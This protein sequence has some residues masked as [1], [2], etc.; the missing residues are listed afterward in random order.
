VI[1]VLV[2]DITKNNILATV[3][4][5]K[6][7]SVKDLYNFLLAVKKDVY[8]NNDRIVITYTTPKQYDLILELLA[9]IDIPEYFVEFNQ[10]DLVSPGIDFSFPESFCIYP[11]IAQQ[12]STLG[13]IQP[14][15]DFD[16][17]LSNDTNYTIASTDLKTAYLSDFMKDI[18]GQFLKGDRPIN[19]RRC[20]QKESVGIKSMRQFGNFK[21]KEFYYNIDYQA[22]NFNNVNAI[23]LRIGNKCNLSCNICNPESSS[24]MAIQM[25][26]SGKLS[27]SE[28]DNIKD[29]VAWAETD[30]FWDQLLSMA[31]NLKYLDIL[32]G[33]PLMSKT[34]FSLLKKLVALGAAKNIKIDYNS[35]GTVFSEKFFDIWKHFKEVKISFS[36]DDIDARFEEQRVGAS[37]QQVCDNLEKFKQHVSTNFI[38]DISSAINTQN[39][40][41]LPELINWTSLQGFDIAVNTVDYPWKYN[42]RSLSPEEKNKI[43]KKLKSN[44][45]HESI[46]SIIKILQE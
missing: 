21:F 33:E 10:I 9:V 40:Y 46:P 29:S 18:R 34:H 5:S 17:T 12:I 22:N 15:C 45:V 14:C 6:C 25:L 41:W 2:V 36:I 7:N 8:Q 37:W 11:W 26:E 28:F 27:K 4:L 23:D 42:I 19:C 13:G 38:I 1:G 43:I 16:A 35:N 20:W 39:V 32:G 3:E 31:N 44:N 30:K 24:T